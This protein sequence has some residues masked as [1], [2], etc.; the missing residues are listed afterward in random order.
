VIYR[1]LKNT[2]SSGDLSTAQEFLNQ[3]IYKPLK[4][5]SPSGDLSAA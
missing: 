5:I 3:V 1:Q 4:N 2:S